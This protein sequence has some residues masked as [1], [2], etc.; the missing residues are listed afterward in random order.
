MTVMA[1]EKLPYDAEHVVIRDEPSMVHA[2]WTS[3]PD[4]A[5]QI[6]DRNTSDEVL[7]RLWRRD[8]VELVAVATRYYTR[9]GADF[10]GWVVEGSGTYSDPIPN[11][12][13]AMQTLRGFIVGY[14]TR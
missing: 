14:F 4:V 11:K 6:R 3:D 9:D 2:F 13:Q 10:T 7:N 8:D 12:R 1:T 5:R